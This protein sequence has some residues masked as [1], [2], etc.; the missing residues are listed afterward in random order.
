MPKELQPL[1]NLLTDAKVAVYAVGGT[2][3]FICLVVIALLLMTSGTNPNRRAAAIGWLGVLIF[4]LILMLM[5]PNI[6]SWVQNVIGPANPVFPTP[7][8]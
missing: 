5:G 4:A 6:G 7:T 8:P 1:Q 3:F 2:V